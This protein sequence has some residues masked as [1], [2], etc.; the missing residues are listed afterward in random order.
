MSRYLLPH[1]DIL[2]GSILDRNYDADIAENTRLLSLPACEV[3]GLSLTTDGA[4][5]YNPVSSHDEF[6]GSQHCI[7]ISHAPCCIRCTRKTQHVEQ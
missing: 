3:F 5:I 4:T 1:R 7:L 6:D 2:G